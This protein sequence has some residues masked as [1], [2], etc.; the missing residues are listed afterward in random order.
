MGNNPAE[1]SLAECTQHR[2]E[3]GPSQNS[4]R[5]PLSM[6]RSRMPHL[7]LILRLSRATAAAMAGSEGPSPPSPPV[8]ASPSGVSVELPLV[9]SLP[10]EVPSSS[11][12]VFREPCANSRLTRVGT[13]PVAVGWGFGEH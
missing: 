12:P 2:T 5:P 10:A 6:D 1:S 3:V 11:L 4:A 7:V 9:A 13:I 8:C